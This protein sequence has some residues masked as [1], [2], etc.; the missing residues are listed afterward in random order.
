MALKKRQIR[1]METVFFDGIIFFLLFLKTDNKIQG[2]IVPIL[3]RDMRVVLRAER[4]MEKE[5]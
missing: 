2:F 5:N 1:D 4:C 3:G